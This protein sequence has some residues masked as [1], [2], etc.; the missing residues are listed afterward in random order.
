M[1]ISR[2]EQQQNHHRVEQV[3]LQ[4]RRLEDHTK[5]V[6]RK[7]FDRTVAERVQRNIRLGLDK[8]TH[9]DVEC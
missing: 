9:V 4:D 6:E 1:K 5:A 3:R 7:K 2:V 8:G